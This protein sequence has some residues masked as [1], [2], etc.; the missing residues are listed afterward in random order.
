MP[1][2]AEQQLCSLIGEMSGE[3]IDRYMTGATG[4]ALMIC[5]HMAF[6]EAPS[7]IE[8]F[9]AS[10][11]RSAARNSQ[12][13]AKLSKLTRWKHEIHCRE[14]RHILMESGIIK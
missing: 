12:E 11:A 9:Q 3:Q 8:A 6:C 13:N 14:I 7:C 2:S 4:E 1:I 10:G 5:Q